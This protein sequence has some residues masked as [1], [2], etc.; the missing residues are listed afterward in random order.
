MS[1]S[2]NII[3]ITTGLEMEGHNWS[4]PCKIGLKDNPRPDN[5][6][7]EEH[8]IIVTLGK[9]LKEPTRPTLSDVSVKSKPVRVFRK[10]DDRQ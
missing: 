6:L 8:K 7:T 5:N 9:K 1:A 3:T 10:N 4:I 2:G